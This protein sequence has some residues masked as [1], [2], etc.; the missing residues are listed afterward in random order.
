M[1]VRGQYGAGSIKGSD[2]PGYR[3]EEGTAEDS[4]TDTFAAMKVMVDT[5]RW[6]GVPF[7]IRTGKRMNRKLT[8]IVVN[9]K[10]TPHPLFK[11]HRES[12]N[13]NQ[14][15]INV[16]PDEGIH[17]RFEGKVPGV[18]MEVRTVNM[19]FNYVEQFQG[20]PPQAYAKMLL[21]AIMGDQTLFKQRDEI[22]Y[23][24]KLVQPI[25]DYWETN[26]DENLPNYAAGTWGP[27]ASDEMLALA[28]HEWYNG[29]PA[30]QDGG[31]EI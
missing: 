15:V 29:D 2:V 6:G 26:P 4:Q 18:E 25:L 14:I 19:H 27:K 13:Q 16:Q 12:L 3:D 20:K 11:G 21:D 7:Y 31:F 9:F 30:I 8:Q 28:G 23:A 22:E 24:W 1:A 17:M 10:P 5:W